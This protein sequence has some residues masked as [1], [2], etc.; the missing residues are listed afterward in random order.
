MPGRRSAPRQSAEPEKIRL[1][2]TNPDPVASLDI[3]SVLVTVGS[4]SFRI[5]ALPASEWLK[6]LLEEALDPEALFPGL[7]DPSVVVS[8]N[9]MMLDGEATG[10]DL[11]EA[12]WDALEAASGRRWFIAVKICAY[13][14]ANWDVIGG[15]LARHGVYPKQMSLS[16]WLDACYSTMLH[17]IGDADPKKLT[18]FT[19]DVTRLPPEEARK[20]DD[21][22]EGNAFLAMM[23]QAQ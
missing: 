1:H 9:Q 18:P 6:V 12:I 4:R 16:A 14:R 8:V 15:E 17:L 20:V 22:A 13:A 11:R 3:Y 23:R 5:P 21:E 19:A 7:C 2:P 10:A